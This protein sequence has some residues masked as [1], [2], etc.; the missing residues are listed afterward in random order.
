MRDAPEVRSVIH[1]R[2]LQLG[3]EELMIAA[4]LDFCARTTEELAPAIDTVEARIRE[5]IA[6]SSP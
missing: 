1:V 2:T 6:G 5:A 3:P 4:K